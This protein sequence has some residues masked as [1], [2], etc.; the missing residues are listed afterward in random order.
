MTSGSPNFETTHWS[1]VLLAAREPDTAA[2]RR[3]LAQLCELYWY[4]IYGFV[5]RRGIQPEDAKD[6]TQGF[7]EHILG[8][9]FLERVDRDRGRF[10]SFLLGALIHYLANERERHA[11][12]RRGGGME[13][14]SIDEVLGEHWLSAEP[15][16]DNDS[17]RAFDRSWSITLINHALKALEDE[18]VLGGKR[19]AFAELKEFLQRSAEPGEYEDVAKRLGLTKGAV[20]VAVHRLN[21]R[22]GELV[23]KNVRETVASTD[24]AEEEMRFLYSAMQG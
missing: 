8:S 12:R 18:Q 5:R 2:G 10:R 23:R 11:A 22:L 3:A 13:K 6:F 16:P 24:M 7:F 17:T 1:A 20:A 21:E 4:P 14:L 15:S 19:A 9:G